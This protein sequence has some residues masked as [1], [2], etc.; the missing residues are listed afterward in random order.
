MKVVPQE[1]PSIPAK[2]AKRTA[3]AFRVRWNHHLLPTFGLDLG[4]L[5]ACAHTVFLLLVLRR[6]LSRP[7]HSQL[8]PHPP[9][10]HPPAQ[11]PL[12]G[13]RRRC[14]MLNSHWSD[15]GKAQARAAWTDKAGPLSC[16]TLKQT[17]SSE[18]RGLGGGGGDVLGR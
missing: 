15:Y 12:S 9:A 17:R 10:Q 6:V 13:A 11:H 8:C 4:P 14:R 3:E 18:K 1:I 5:T 16:T 2:A 7:S